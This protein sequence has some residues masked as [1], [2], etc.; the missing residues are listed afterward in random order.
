MHRRKPPFLSKLSGGTAAASGN[1]Q[2]II[3]AKPIRDP[4][5]DEAYRYIWIQLTREDVMR[6]LE[7][8]I[9]KEL[10]L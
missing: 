8:L 10:T 3:V 2:E 9:M 7:E 5:A 6:L 4:C 1:C